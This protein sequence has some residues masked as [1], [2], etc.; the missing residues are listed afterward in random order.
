MRVNVA[1]L[2]IFPGRS[3]VQTGERQGSCMTCSDACEGKGGR[4]RMSLAAWTYETT[5]KARSEGWPSRALRA[6]AGATARAG[7]A[8]SIPPGTSAPCRSAP[9][10][11]IAALRA[12]S[13]SRLER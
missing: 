3:G 11:Q 2:R 9:R 13:P 4:S 8:S 7:S 1:E 12:A 10:T 6:R 5:R